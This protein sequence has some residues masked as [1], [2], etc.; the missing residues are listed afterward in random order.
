MTA[1]L[2]FRNRKATVSQIIFGIGISAC[3]AQPGSDS[4]SWQGEALLHDDTRSR[5][6]VKPSLAI[7]A[8]VASLSTLVGCGK[9]HLS[10]K[11][12]IQLGTGE[13]V[14]A[15]RSARTKS[16]R[17]VG[18][19]GGWENEG[20]TVEIVGALKDKPP[21]WDYPFV[22]LL[23]D[24]DTET[25][26][27]FMVATFY[28]CPSWY[29][30][31]RPKLPYVEYRINDGQWAAQALSPNLTG[32]S[33]NMLTNIRSGGEPNHTIATKAAVMSDPMI[34]REYKEIVD[35]WS[36]GC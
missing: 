21:R 9:S 34:A 22:P 12:E 32:R 28:G 15:Q 10:W 27:W 24:R 25:K 4:T 30:L 18:G 31:G 6:P 29:D 7:L 13:V 5:K 35:K 20:M 1:L 3:A 14:L 8:L 17:E 2:R 23:F 11:E 36:T 26:Q 33:A 19:P 16:F